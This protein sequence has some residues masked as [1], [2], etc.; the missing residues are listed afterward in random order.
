M[1]FVTVS[2]FLGSH[3]LCLFWYA[4]IIPIVIFSPAPVV[5]ARHVKSS[6]PSVS[7]VPLN[8]TSWATWWYPWL[9]GHV[10]QCG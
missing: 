2:L 8:H 10:R 3:Y 7:W 5:C 1:F 4:G 9:W 6:H